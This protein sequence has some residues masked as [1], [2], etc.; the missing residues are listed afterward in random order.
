MS[1]VFA[2][3]KIIGIVLLALFLLVLFLLLLLLFA[4][5][6]YRV[7][8]V[9]EGAVP[10][11]EASASYLFPLLR[12]HFSYREKEGANG[13]LRLLWFSFP[14]E[15]K[16]EKED[17]PKKQHSK[18]T[19]K[20]QM[21]QPPE[22]TSAPPKQEQIPKKQPVGSFSEEDDEE[23]EELYDFDFSDEM[24]QIP[25]LPAS[26]IKRETKKENKTNK[27][28]HNIHLISWIWHLFHRIK[29]AVLR[30][31]DRIKHFQQEWAQTTDKVKRLKQLYDAE[32]TKLAIKG[33]KKEVFYVLKK[34][35][36]QKIRGFIRFGCSDPA[37]TGEL[38]GAASMFYAYFGS[39]LKL[40]PD[41][42]EA[43]LSVDILIKGRLRLIYPVV[44]VIKLF[45]NRALK[46]TIKRYKHITG[47]N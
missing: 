37:Q 6:R 7:K 44:A 22:Q 4:P 40:Y 31:Y 34:E 38:L 13:H 18:P 16:Q 20:A 17:K 23:E 26:P 28:E 30:L 36:P 33:V 15:E 11:V 9:L 2:I 47:G 45:F 35:R 41:F 39:S 27:T 12:F 24:E 3:L 10:D 42:N 29:E 14:K 21:R 25:M 32:L 46:K 8:L 5:V 19:E 43:C 1:I